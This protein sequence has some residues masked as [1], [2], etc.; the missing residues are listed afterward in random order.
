MN[1]A[2][3]RRILG[4]LALIAVLATGMPAMVAAA[5][6]ATISFHGKLNQN[7]S[8]VNGTVSMTFRLYSAASG[9]T[10]LWSEATVS[11]A[12]NGVSAGL[13]ALANAAGAT[14]RIQVT[15]S[16]VSQADYGL[17]A[18]ILAGGTASVVVSE[19]MLTGNAVGAQ[20]LGAGASVRSLGNNTFADNTTDVA[21]GSLAAL[22]GM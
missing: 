17:L 8:A 13:N 2:G 21:G 6:P 9:G 15:R 18:S 10:P 14:A 11:G 22:G 12:M 5:P 3:L 7:G 20:I 4:S 19:S 16:V 1:R